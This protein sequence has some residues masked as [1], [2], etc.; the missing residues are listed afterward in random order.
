MLDEF[1]SSDSY[2][3]TIRS[4]VGWLAFI[5]FIAACAAIIY[6]DDIQITQTQYQETPTIYNVRIFGGIKIVDGM[7]IALFIILIVYQ[8]F[9]QNIVLTP[10]H[11]YIGIVFAVYCYAALIGFIYSFFY[12]Y[13]YQIW[14]QDFQQTIYM[15]GFFLLTFHIL[16]SK[17]KWKIFIVFFLSILALKNVLI[18]QA[19]LVGAGKAIG[20]WAF[21]ASQNA[22]FAYFPMLFFPLLLLMLNKISSILKVFMGFVLL[23][24]IFN[25]LIGIYRTVWVMLLVGLFYLII[26]LDN[27]K[28]IILILSGSLVL[29]SVLILIEGLFPKFLSLAWNYKFASI[30]EWSLEGDRSNATRRLELIN[31]TNHVFKN[32]AFLHGMGLGAWWDDSTRKLLPDLGSGFTYKARYYN[33]HMWWLT[34]FLKLGL[35]PMILYWLSI[36]KIFHRIALFVKAMS[37]NEWEKSVLLGL[38]IGLLCSFVSSADFVR[39]FLVIGINIGASASYIYLNN[40]KIGVSNISFSR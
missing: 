31:V 40:Q 12:R 28:R 17:I 29:G 2:F 11:R 13:D 6:F 30:F 18:F 38:N 25:S 15:V 3:L 34:Q 24:Y 19:S 4:L 37:W 8:F 26:Q 16:D 27:K 5:S 23:V 32:F 14:L 22:E 33:T 9:H 1:K 7:S 21:R 20:G 35:I 10:F 39:L 36:Y